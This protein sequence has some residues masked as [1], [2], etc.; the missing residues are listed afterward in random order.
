MAPVK[1]L[2]FL[3]SFLCTAFQNVAALQP[4][5]FPLA[6]TGQ[7]IILPSFGGERQSSSVARVCYLCLLVELLSWEIRW[8]LWKCSLWDRLCHQIQISQTMQHFFGTRIRT[9]TKTT[10]WKQ[11]WRILDPNSLA[12]FALK[13]WCATGSQSLAWLDGRT[14]QS[15]P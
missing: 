2:L 4:F 15:K 14:C 12:T 13:S 1:W 5:H 10:E 9:E 7:C 3:M 11:S 8:E 6:Q